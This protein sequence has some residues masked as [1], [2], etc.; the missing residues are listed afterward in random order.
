LDSGRHPFLASPWDNLA[1]Q[2]FD[3]MLQRIMQED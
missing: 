1:N 3:T 2:T